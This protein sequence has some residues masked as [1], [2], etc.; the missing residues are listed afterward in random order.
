MAYTKYSLTPADNNAAPPNGA[1][2]GMLPSAVNDTM[3][4]MMAQ[5]RDVG[6]GIRGGTY[7]MTAPV[8]TGGTITGVALTGNTFTSPVISGGSINN[9]PI[10]ATTANTGAFTTLSATGNVSFDGGS[11]VFNETGAD[12]D[13][14]FEGDTDAN[15]LFLD[16]STDRIGIGTSSPGAKLSVR[17][18]NQIVDTSGIAYVGSSNAQAAN[19]GGQLSLGGSAL[20]AGTGDAPFAGIAGRKEN[21]TSGN[22]AGYLQFSSMTSGGTL[23]ERMRLNSSGALVLAGGTTSADGI[24][25][26]FPATQ[27]AST[28]ANTLDDYEEGTFTPALAFSNASAGMTYSRQLGTY[29]KIGRFV[30]FSVEIVLTSKG[31]STGAASI[32]NLPFSC[33]GTNGFTGSAV[34]VYINSVNF[35]T[36]ANYNI[37]IGGTSVALNQGGS[38]GSGNYNAGNF[39]N[40]STIYINGWYTAA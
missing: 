10:G 17:A 21:S 8:I 37:G 30:Y 39:N 1:P 33:I 24:G 12:K 27:S 40:N 38:S 36:F 4:D 28:N 25:I 35:W 29:T 34:D 2:E 18:A 15:L 5:I 20:D 26:T 9:T 13:A 7:T 23:T 22:Y 32:N 31:S 16:A 3:R 19:L 6:D 11:F 14:R